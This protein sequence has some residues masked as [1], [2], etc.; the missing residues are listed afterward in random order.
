MRPVL[1]LAAIAALLA[2]PLAAQPVPAPEGHS[3]RLVLGADGVQVYACEAR[4]GAHAWVFKG[5]E[6]A[7][8]DAAGR[9]VGTHGAGP[10]WR[11]SADG[12]TVGGEVAATAAAPVAGAIPWL[13]LRVRQRE[14]G[15]GFGGTA[16]IR[17]IDTVGGAP[18]REGCDAAQAGQV[19]RMR[20]AATYEFLGE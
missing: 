17:R 19:A 1:P 9:Q 2:V 11:L 18:P 5:P 20:Y 12:A 13:L 4:A 8:F 15:A 10:F 7:L 14:G 3:V 16:W 6:A